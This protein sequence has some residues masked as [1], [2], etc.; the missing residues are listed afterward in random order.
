MH[1]R[2]VWFLE[3]IAAVN[4]RVDENLTILSRSTAQTLM[5]FQ[6]GNSVH[7]RAVWLLENIAVVNV[8]VD[9]NLIIPLRSTAQTLTN[10]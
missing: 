5:N 6:S 10:F 9:E 8:R 4:V 7:Q 1:Q 2:A 3:N